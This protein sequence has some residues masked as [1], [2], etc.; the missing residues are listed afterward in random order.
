MIGNRVLRW[1]ACP[2]HAFEQSSAGCSHQR[3]RDDLGTPRRE[4][5]CM[6]IGCPC[7]MAVP[8]SGVG[9]PKMEK[10]PRVSPTMYGPRGLAASPKVSK[11]VRRNMQANRSKNTQPE[12][13]IRRILWHGGFRGYRIHLK[14]LPGKPDVVFTKLRIAIFVHGCFWHGCPKCEA[15]RCPKTNAAYWAAKRA[16]NLDRDSKN[17]ATLE[18]LGYKV[19]V[20][21]ECEIAPRLKATLTNKLSSQLTI[22]RAEFELSSDV[23]LGN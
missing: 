2:N 23:R 8:Q 13:A 4:L 1:Q 6:L 10:E 19:I 9:I 5:S 3:L 18:K 12:L 14:H 20:V 21:W 15:K 16:Y 17:V 7:R 11:A 22:F